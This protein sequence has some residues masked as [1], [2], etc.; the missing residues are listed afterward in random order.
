MRFGFPLSEKS[1]FSIGLTGDATKIDLESDT[2]IQYIDFCGNTSGCNAN[3]IQAK[4]S[5]TYD[6]RDNLLFPNRGTLQRLKGE[7][8]IPGLD[9]EYYKIEYQHSWFKDIFKNVVVM[10]NG[11]LGYADS[12][13]DGVYPFFKNF[14]AG[15]VNSIRG[16]ENGALGPRDID[17]ATNNEF[18][19]GGTTRIVGNAEV[20]VPVPF[21]KDSSQFRISAFLDGG[22]VFAEGESRKLSELRYSAGLGLSWFSPFGPLKLVFAQPLNEEDGDQTETLQFQFGQQF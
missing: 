3:S 21:I 11:E 22:T 13:G 7:V 5:W 16:Y 8:T 4:A 20:F 14:Y 2:P 1:G 6:S 17:P 12:Y 9:L 18:S 10:L 15:G 19:V